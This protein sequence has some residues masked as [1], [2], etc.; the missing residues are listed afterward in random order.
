MNITK[1][2][3]RWPEHDIDT[4][5]TF[6]GREFILVNR[7]PK[8]V[9]RLLIQEIEYVVRDRSSVIF[10]I[11]HDNLTVEKVESKHGEAQT[12]L[13]GP[14]HLGIQTDGVSYSQQLAATARRSGYCVVPR[15]PMSAKIMGDI[16]LH[17]VP[18]PFPSGPLPQ[19]PLNAVIGL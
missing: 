2:I 17:T 7:Q 10:S 5:T 1:Q 12:A 16:D 6:D 13:F 9:Q 14:Q 8:A 11:V 4:A 15:P 19:L 18:P 3:D